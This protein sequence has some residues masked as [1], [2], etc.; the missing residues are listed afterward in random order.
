M[1]KRLLDLIHHLEAGLIERAIPARLALLAALSG[2]HLLLLGPPGTAKSELARKLHQIFSS[3][4]YF[5]RLLT[6]F[7]VPEELFGPLSIKAL[8]DDRYQRLTEGYLPQASIAFIDE[9]FKSNSAIL[10]SLL[11][12]LNEREFDNGNERVKVPL[13]CVI[14]ASNEMPEEA[15]LDAL[16]DR[17]LVRYQ[18]APVSDKGFDALLKLSMDNTQQRHSH[19][20]ESVLDVKDIESIQQRSAAVVLDDKSLKIMQDLR[21]H[22]QNQSI[23]ISD[24]RWRQTLKLLQ[25]CAYT[26]EQNQISVWDCTLMMHIMWQLPEQQVL[27]KTW[28]IDALGLDV[29][30]AELRIRKLVEAWEFQLAEDSKKITHK[31]SEQG[32][33]LYTDLSGKLTTQHEH[34]SFA[35]R[36]GE[37]LYLAPSDQPDRT[38]QNKGYTLEELE[39]TFFDRN[40]KQTHI[41]GHWIDVQNYINNTQNKL[42]RRQVFEPLVE[43]FYF[44]REHVAAQLVEIEQTIEDVS[45]ICAGFEAISAELKT[46]LNNNIWLASGMLEDVMHTINLKMPVLAEFQQRLIKLKEI[47]TRL[48]VK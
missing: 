27:L 13:I 38:N 32:E 26:S 34:V 4:Q 17:F 47:N 42:V 29:V 35:E 39:S 9:I 11:T 16:Y 6:R 30:S 19:L 10:N 31:T 37:A 25:V 45:G 3:T 8:E 41:N 15:G 46:V 12:L 21:R 1:R 36:N 24:R 44:P 7:T 28:F 43:A 48:S 23:Y 40:Y 18:V 2:E 5:E 14:A 33:D 20:L 22:L